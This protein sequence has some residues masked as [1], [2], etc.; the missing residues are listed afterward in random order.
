MIPKVLH[1]KHLPGW[2]NV[3]RRDHKNQEVFGPR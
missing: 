1:R 2:G 3:K